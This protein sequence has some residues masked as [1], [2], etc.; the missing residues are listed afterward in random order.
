M[1]HK[2][3]KKTIIAHDFTVAA[4]DQAGRGRASGTSLINA[5]EYAVLLADNN[6]LHESR[7]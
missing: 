6:K 5:I 3:V 2:V 1:R 7:K 4:F